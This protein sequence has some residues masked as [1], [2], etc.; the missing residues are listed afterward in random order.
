MAEVRLQE[1]IQQVDG[2][3]EKGQYDEAIAH[4][5][6]ILQH[7]P[8]FLLAYRLLGK[9]LLETGQDDAAEEMFLRV[10][11]GDPEDFVARVGMSVIHDR[12]GDLQRAIWHMERAFELAPE[13]DVIQ[14]ELRRLYGRRDGVVPP[15]VMLTHGALARLYARGGLF[16][17]AVETLRSLLAKEPERVDLRVALA[18]ALWNDGQ[19]VQAEDVCLRVLDE[20]PYCLKANLILGEIWAR[21][22]RDEAQVHLRRAEA[23]DPENTRAVEIL[24]DASPLPPREVQLP[25]LE[26][27]VPEVPAARPGVGVAVPE[28]RALVDLE[29]AAEIQIEIPAWLEE[30]GLGEE[31]A[32]SVVE[33]EGI[34]VP[35]WL[36]PEEAAPEV[37]EA[38]APAE[39]PEWLRELAPPEVRAPEAPAPAEIPEWLREV[40]PPEV[41]APEAPAPAEIPE[42]LREVAPPEVRAPEAPAPAE[43]P[44]WLREVAPPEAEAPEA[45]APAEIPEWLREVA[46]PEVEA[47][48]APAPAEIPEWLR[49][50]APPEVGAPE[51]PAPAEIPEW[52]REVAPPE[53]RAPEA[54]APAEI[55]E[56]LRE[57]AP[58]EVRA[59]EAPAPAE[60]PEWLR[61]VAPPEV[62]APEAPAP[63]AI[64]SWL[65]EGRMPEGEEALAW[66]ASLAAGREAELRAAAEAEAEARIAEIMGREVTTPAAAAPE[67]PEAPAA[68]EAPAPEVV[69]SWL[70]EGRMPEGEEA[71]AWLASL[72]AGRE[73]EL[74]AAAEAEAEARMAEIMGREVTPPAAAAPE[75]PEAPAAP[76]APAPVE[77]PEWLREAAPP[78]APV[79]AEIPEW[80]R[81]LAPPEVVAPEVPEEEEIPEWLRG[82]APPEAVAPEVPEE[83]ELPE[84]LRGV[85]MPEVPEVEERPGWLEEA[86]PPEAAVPELEVPEWLEEVVPPE[87]PR[88]EVPPAEPEMFGWTSFGAEVEILQPTPPIEEVSPPEQPFGWTAFGEA[89][90][91]PEAPAWREPEVLAA[92]V[93]PSPTVLPEVAPPPVMP[94]EVVPPPPAR[95]EAVPPAPPT[96]EALASIDALRAYVRS[97]PRDHEARLNLARA[98]WQ[99]GLYADSLEAYSRLLKA[100][101]L[102]DEVLADMEAHV[103]ERPND[104]AVRRV[105]GDAYMRADRLADALA[106]YREALELVTTQFSPKLGA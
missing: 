25:Y 56:W 62:R 46:P 99:A 98:L 84:W 52:L 48:E 88:A 44:E 31:G 17:R 2:M 37:S 96:A 94:P 95:P 77:I 66:L 32:P 22:G 27:G 54:P 61:E 82:V 43:I 105:L 26:Y 47:P 50:V 30:I 11:S 34:A 70:E 89:V 19:R 78:E 20:L 39:I 103:A 7:Y 55:P 9:I 80:L 35:S 12:R 76:E 97:H 5:R 74:R 104:P 81:E 49:E 92:E 28:E 14:E 38:P 29:R 6:H 69:P 13:N 100:G 15:R 59:P 60:I 4:L 79:P 21:S 102:L 86:V 10:L 57:V 58:P 67:V 87:V 91:A 101:R 63:E 71:L 36:M 85:P 16:S 68:P 72:A 1:Y 45:P 64:P 33:E 8:K 93:A 75:V 42:W 106:T 90:V 65:E 23:L 83:E 41:G 24:G 18:E 53:A 73:A 3:V 40:A 51:A